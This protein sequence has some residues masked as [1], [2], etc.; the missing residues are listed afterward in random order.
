MSSAELLPAYFG[1]SDKPLF[2]CYSEPRRSRRRTT[3]VVIS[4]PMGHEYINSHRALRQLAIRLSNI[5]F[6]V[7][8]FDYSGCGDS[9]GEGIACRISHWM[10]DLSEA[11]SEVQRRSGVASVTLIGLRFGATLSLMAS[12]QRVDVANLVLWD[13]VIS[14]KDYLRGLFSLNKELLRFRPK[15]GASKT[16]WPKD[17]IG[18]PLTH[19]LY[20]DIDRIDLRR[21]RNRTTANMLFLE[22]ETNPAHECLKDILESSGATVAFQHMDA[23]QIWIPT[24]D[25][26][27]QVPTSVLQFVSSW[28]DRTCS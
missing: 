17:V 11:I 26:G 8:R 24:V 25:G 9:S 18:F 20:D 22:T 23:P 6:P 7:F 28:A 19:D 27:L 15:P 4:Q 14:G 5:G 10:D 21:L 3:A 1:S 2:G 16:E 12:A 13:P